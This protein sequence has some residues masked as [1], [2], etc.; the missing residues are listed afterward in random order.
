MTDLY[1][2][3]LLTLRRRE[4]IHEFYLI[5]DDIEESFQRQGL[6]ARPRLHPDRVPSA[7]RASDR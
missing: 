5:C 2:H 1:S 3:A 7:P 4:P 6:R